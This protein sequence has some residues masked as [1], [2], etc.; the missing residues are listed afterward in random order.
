MILP[1]EVIRIGKVRK[2]NN[3]KGELLCLLE[4]DLFAEVLPP[5]IVLR[6]DNILV[7]FHIENYRFRGEDQLLLQ[8]EAITDERQAQR[9][10]SAELYLLL[11]DLPQEIIESM[12]QPTLEGF[13]LIDE[14]KGELGQIVAIDD[15]TINVLWKLNN[16]T[17]IPAHQD[18]IRTVDTAKKIVFTSLPE[19][20]L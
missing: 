15:S 9:L 5:F 10:C 18:F 14:Q 11:S 7:P 16:G 1:D 13:T 19:G 4:N 8:L 3:A 2:T 20:L 17:L 6:C 12:P